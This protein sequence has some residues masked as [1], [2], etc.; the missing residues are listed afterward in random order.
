MKR[1]VAGIA[2][3]AVLALAF[4]NQAEARIFTPQSHWWTAGRSCVDSRDPPGLRWDDLPQRACIARDNTQ[5]GPPREWDFA[6]VNDKLP[7][8]RV[9]LSLKEPP[10]VSASAEETESSVCS[11]RLQKRIPLSCVVVLNDAFQQALPG[12]GQRRVTAFGDAEP[13]TGFRH[14]R[15][16]WI[17]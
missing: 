5:A 2:I 12:I 7:T 15:L 1:I 11:A 16:D 6:L 10:K 9:A 8:W 13:F 17:D 3:A 14:G 4:V